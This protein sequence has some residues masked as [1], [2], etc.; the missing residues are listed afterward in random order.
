MKNFS[1]IEVAWWPADKKAKLYSSKAR[2]WW[3]ID[4]LQ[5][6][7]N[8]LI[9]K[10]YGEKGDILILQKPLR[11]SLRQKIEPLLKN[12][13]IVIFDLSDGVAD[14]S[15]EESQKLGII[16][17]SNFKVFSQKADFFV[18]NGIGLQKWIE[19]KIQKPAFI[20]EDPY[21]I[22]Y[23][24]KFV[25][26]HKETNSL[27]VAWHGGGKLAA[28]FVEGYLKGN[29]QELLRSYDNQEA[30]LGDLNELLKTRVTVFADLSY[31]K[32]KKSKKTIFKLHP[33]YPKLFKKLIKYDIGIAPYWMWD[34]DC[35]CKSTNKID[36]MMLVGLPII[37]TPIPENKRLIVNGVNGFLCETKQEWIDAFSQLQSRDLREKIGLAGR[38][39]V[40]EKRSVPFLANQWRKL[41]IQYAKSI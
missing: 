27:K 14:I 41:F 36:A 4:Y 19:D 20:I 33:Q 3:H 6:N 30:Y 12:F 25:K 18:V 10:P 35:F 9:I 37:A 5:K 22:G 11:L 29:S 39:T 28:L 13:K 8:D 7:F 1:K 23:N 40:I 16:G 15:E 32:Y 31:F 38:A 2:A 26:E 34:P 17:L 24:T 21:H